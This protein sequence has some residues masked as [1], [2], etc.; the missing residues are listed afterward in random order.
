[1]N[2]IEQLKTQIA[3]VEEQ[4]VNK[5]AEIEAKQYEIDHFEYERTEQEYDDFIDE[6]DEMVHVGGLTFYPSD[7]LKSC[8]PIGYRCAKSEYESNYDLEECEEWRQLDEKLLE[9]R[10]ELEDLEGDFE[11]VS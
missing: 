5:Q 8:D 7:V 9:L 4:I 1:M 6:V 10:Y 3:K 11:A 2:T